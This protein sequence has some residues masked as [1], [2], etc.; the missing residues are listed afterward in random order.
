M[1]K[2]K[3]ENLYPRNNSNASRPCCIGSKRGASTL[4]LLIFAAVF[5]IA[6]VSFVSLKFSGKDNSDPG[7][8]FIGKTSAIILKTFGGIFSSS[9]EKPAL[10]I[11]LTNKSVAQEKISSAAN[12]SQTKNGKSSG[13]TLQNNSAAENESVP[14]KNSS[15]TPSQEK[16]DSMQSPAL[17]IKKVYSACDFSK[18]GNSSRKVILNEINWVGSDTSAGDEWIELKN[19]SGSEI[20]L[21]GWQILSGDGDMKII[22]EDGN[23]ISPGTFYLLE[24]TDDDSAPGIAADATYSGA[25]SNSGEFLKIFDTDCNISDEL[26]ASKGWQAGNSSERKT[27]EISSLDLSWHTSASPGGTPKKENSMAFVTKNFERDSQSTGSQTNSN[28]DSSSQNEPY[29][30]QTQNQTS[31]SSTQSP[32]KILISEIFY[33]PAGSD[34][35]KEFI[36]LFNAGS[37]NVDLSGW[38][39]KNGT[40]SLALIGSKSEDK[41]AVV[42]GGYFLIGLNGYNSAPSAD[43]IRSTPLPN[44]TATINLYDSSVSLIESVSYNNSVAEGESYERVS[45]DS[46]EFKTEPNPNPQNSGQ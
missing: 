5:T 12:A 18:S 37:Q 7:Q 44:T 2:R 27:M 41:K 34:A 36:E 45:W 10:E 1:K 28:N 26:D 13:A 30:S 25:L 8:S 42:P 11:D 19:N 38:S 40:N 46:G 32:A 39:L 4:A 15:D 14:Q 6:S 31:T 22:L 17:E 33:N 29:G 3:K 21:A 23:K 35:G 9:G 20:D 16:N 24:R 43:V